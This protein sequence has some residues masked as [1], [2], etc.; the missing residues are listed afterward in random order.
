MHSAGFSIELDE[1]ARTIIVS[2]ELDDPAIVSLRE[3]VVEASGS[4]TRPLAID[5]SAVSF[6]PSAAVGVLATAQQR[7]STSGHPVDLVAADGTIAQR[8]LTVCAL[9]YRVA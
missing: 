4:F 5:L 2:G 3:A 1:A 8:V 6:I 9:P 7:G